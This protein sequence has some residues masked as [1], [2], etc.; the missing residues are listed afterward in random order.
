[1]NANRG[2]TSGSN[3]GSTLGYKIAVGIFIIIAV[4]II[5]YVVYNT[6]NNYE[7][8]ERDSPYLIKDTKLANSMTVVPAYKIRPSR[9]GRYGMEFTYSMWIYID[10]W[11]YKNGEYKNVLVKGDPSGELLQAPGIFLD[12]NENNL[13]INMNTYESVRETVKIS[14]VPLNKWFLLTVVLINNNIDVYINAGLK[15][16][17]KLNGVPKLNFSDVYIGDFQGMIS[18]V[19]YFNRALEYYLIARIFSE[20]PSKKPCTEDTD[21]DENYL[22]KN[23]WL[24]TGHPETQSQT[25]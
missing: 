21:S 25:N 9:D 3:Y 2:S 11:T 14:G 4:A 1:M 16:R 15:K 13:L 17:H 20:G 18:K 12:K 10:N 19:R 7:N 5:S 24:N 8:Y 23:W 6:Y 22:A